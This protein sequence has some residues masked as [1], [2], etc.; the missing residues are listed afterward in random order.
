MRFEASSLDKQRETSQKT[1]IPSSL[2]S[3]SPRKKRR[4][5]FDDDG[6]RNCRNV[7]NFLPK[8]TNSQPRIMGSAVRISNFARLNRFTYNDQ[9]KWCERDDQ[10]CFPY[11]LF[12]L[13]LF[14]DQDN[15][16]RRHISVSKRGFCL[17]QLCSNCRTSTSARTC[18]SNTSFHLPHFFASTFFSPSYRCFCPLN[19]SSSFKT[20]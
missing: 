19:F 17:Y 7:G 4:L 15:D 18:V 16:G 14:Q 3:R 1:V 2:G 10:N 13:C 6:N 5:T 9:R 12:V 11:S 8:D 20:S